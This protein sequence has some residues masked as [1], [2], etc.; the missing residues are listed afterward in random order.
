MKSEL[1]MILRTDHILGNTMRDFATMNTRIW[2]AGLGARKDIAGI[3]SGWEDG[4][5]GS[6]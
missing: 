1:R 4:N 2:M 3:T 6:L 5:G